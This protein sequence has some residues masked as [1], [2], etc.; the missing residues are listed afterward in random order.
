M[1]PT[2]RR[3]ELVLALLA[4]LAGGWL[5]HGANGLSAEPPCEYG[6]IFTCTPDLAHIFQGSCEGIDCYSGMEFCCSNEPFPN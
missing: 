3:I 2:V 5:F 6:E 4:L 1:Q